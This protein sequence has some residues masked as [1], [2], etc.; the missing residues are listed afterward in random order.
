MIH[1]LDYSTYIKIHDLWLYNLQIIRLFS[2]FTLH[3]NITLMLFLKRNYVSVIGT[4]SKL[5]SFDDIRLTIVLYV[6]EYKISIRFFSGKFKDICGYYSCL[7]YLQVTLNFCP[8]FYL[9]LNLSR[10]YTKLVG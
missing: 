8:L 5:F 3:R 7:H 10:L 4:G 9:F 6:W 1:F 2:H